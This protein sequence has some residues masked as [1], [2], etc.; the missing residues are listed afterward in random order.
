MDKFMNTAAMASKFPEYM[1]IDDGVYIGYILDITDENFEVLFPFDKPGGRDKIKYPKNMT[2]RR[3]G[4]SSE[5][6]YFIEGIYGEPIVV[7]YKN[8]T[9]KIWNALSDLRAEEKRVIA[10]TPFNEVVTFDAEVYRL[11][12]HFSK[13]AMPGTVNHITNAYV[14]KKPDDTAFVVTLFRKCPIYFQWKNMRYDRDD[15]YSKIDELVHVKGVSPIQLTEL[16]TKEYDNDY[17]M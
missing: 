16:L 3:N 7:S 15:L 9:I 10:I 12:E 13:E 2:V 11:K 8:N 6:D 17:G 5:I 14:K 1:G 4:V